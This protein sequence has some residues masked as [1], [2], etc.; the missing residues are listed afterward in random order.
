[1]SYDKKCENSHNLG[2]Q[3]KVLPIFRLY[4]KYSTD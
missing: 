2:L 1:M 3:I 4:K